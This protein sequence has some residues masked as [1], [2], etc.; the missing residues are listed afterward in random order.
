MVLSTGTR[1]AHGA[2]V[3]FD[4]VRLVSVSFL[5]KWHLGSHCAMA[6]IGQSLRQEFVRLADADGT[7]LHRISFVSWC[8]C[9]TISIMTKKVKASWRALACMT[10]AST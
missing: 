8:S 4:A 10:V 9:Q 5:F 7:L 3:P 6:S 2:E 1:L